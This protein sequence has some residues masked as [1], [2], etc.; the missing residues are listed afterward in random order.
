MRH[1]TSIRICDQIEKTVA[2][3]QYLK[4]SAQTDSCDLPFDFYPCIK[5]W[6]LTIKPDGCQNE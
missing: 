2:A 5:V 3:R 4:G 6:V 1:F